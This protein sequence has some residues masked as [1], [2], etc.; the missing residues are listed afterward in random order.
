MARRS[1]KRISGLERKDYCES[2][3][4]EMETAKP[5]IDEL[6]IIVEKV[7][8]VF[9]LELAM[10]NWKLFKTEKHIIL[11]KESP[12]KDSSWEGEKVS[13]TIRRTM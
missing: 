8:T 6:G 4:I 2:P 10:G 7:R 13:S 1:S 11:D 3:T 5:E 9:G 12:V